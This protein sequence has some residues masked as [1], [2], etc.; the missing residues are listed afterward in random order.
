M[1]TAKRELKAGEVLDGEGGYTVVGT[2][3]PAQDSLRAGALPRGRAHEGKRLRPVTAGETVRWSDVA[4][5]QTT[6][7]A[8]ARR[9]MERAFAPPAEAAA[10]AGRELNERRARL[11]E[12]SSTR[13]T[14]ASRPGNDGSSTTR[15][16][17]GSP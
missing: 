4:N 14:T 15:R 9:E 6:S 5:D 2:L 13:P 3:K 17:N 1:A 12:A 7:A 8:R 16:A 10:A 11:R